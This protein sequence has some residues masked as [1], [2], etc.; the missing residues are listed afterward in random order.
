MRNPSTRRANL[1]EVIKYVIAAYETHQRMPATDVNLQW[2]PLLSRIQRNPS[3][4]AVVWDRVLAAVQTLEVKQ[5]D[6]AAQAM[7]LQQQQGGPPTR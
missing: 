5:Q 1:D 7:A 2:E 3:C 6:E 4:D